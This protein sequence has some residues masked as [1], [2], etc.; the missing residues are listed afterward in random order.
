MKI[1]PS[2]DT[3]TE[4]VGESPHRRQEPIFDQPAGDGE[5]RRKLERTARVAGRS[6][7]GVVVFRGRFLDLL[8]IEPAGVLELLV[9]DPRLAAEP[10]RAEAEHQRRGE[11]PRLG[12]HV[13][14]PPDGDAGLLA[15]LARHR[16]L[17][18]LA[19]AAPPR[20]AP[21]PPRAPPPPPPPGAPGGAR[22]AGGAPN[23]A[24]S[25]TQRGGGAAP[26]GLRRSPA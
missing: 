11:R 4:R 22:G 2:R 8:T 21:R 6:P 15:D 25:P 20:G 16:L 1:H 12:I 9:A 3:A 10:R 26:A 24:G 7:P 14:R 23:G 19:G 17:E 18:A 5:P 13:A